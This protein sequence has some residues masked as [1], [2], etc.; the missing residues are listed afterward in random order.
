MQQLL[1]DAGD[2]LRLRPLD[3]FRLEIALDLLRHEVEAGPQLAELVGA[4]HRNAGGQ[5]APRDGF[6]RLR[7][8]AHR[9]ENAL[10]KRRSG[11]QRHQRYAGRE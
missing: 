10:Q 8:R 6:G 2:F 1:A 4:R 7:K 5:V 3:D 9:L 11:E